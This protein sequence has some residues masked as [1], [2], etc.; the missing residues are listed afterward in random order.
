LYQ[1]RKERAVEKFLI[2]S[3]LHT[4]LAGHDPPENLTG[5]DGILAG[6][7]ISPGTRGLN[8]LLDNLPPYLNII[9]LPGNHEYYKHNYPALL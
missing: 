5:V 9:Y 7:D 2:L 8:W 4:D 1:L 6:G 3:D